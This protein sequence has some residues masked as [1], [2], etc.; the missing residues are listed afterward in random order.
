MS[1]FRVLSKDDKLKKKLNIE[2]ECW[3]YNSIPPPFMPLD[4]TYIPI[5]D[6]S[7]LQDINDSRT[8]I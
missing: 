3:S 7:C 6:S 5:K 1:F 4:F 8:D 2:K